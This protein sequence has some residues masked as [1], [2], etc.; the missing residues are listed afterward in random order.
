MG[1]IKKEWG[2]SC[3]WRPGT[4]GAGRVQ[5]LVWFLAAEG[6]MK[7]LGAALGELSWVLNVWGN[8]NSIGLAPDPTAGVP[9]VPPSLT[10]PSP[11]LDI[12]R[13]QLCG[14]F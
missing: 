12:S 8:G 1:L 14:C 7:P 3:P 2:C 5:T 4:A 6:S 11:G 10:A 9:P 13:V